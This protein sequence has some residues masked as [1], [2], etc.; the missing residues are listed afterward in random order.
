MAQFTCDEGYIITKYKYKYVIKNHN[1]SNYNNVCYHEV[2]N[3]LMNENADDIILLPNPYV[4]W[5]GVGY[6]I[7]PVSDNCSVICINER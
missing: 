3:S 5:T 1:A 2:A 7:N 6:I 4:D